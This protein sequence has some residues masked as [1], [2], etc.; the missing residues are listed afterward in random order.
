M[1]SGSPERDYATNGSKQAKIKE[2]IQTQM[3]N[4]PILPV[5]SSKRNHADALENKYFSERQGARPSSSRMGAPDQND[6]NKTSWNNRSS[7]NTNQ[8]NNAGQYSSNAKP[9]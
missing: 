2:K 1:N 4:N 9:G 8:A 7:I 3:K 6:L 5:R